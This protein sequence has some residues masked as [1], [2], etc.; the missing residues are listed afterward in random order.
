M[1]LNAIKSP[2]L[3][4]SPFF[5]LQEKTESKAKQSNTLQHTTSARGSSSQH[6]SNS[7]EPI[8]VGSSSDDEDARILHENPSTANE[9]PH[10]LY[11]VPSPAHEFPRVAQYQPNT[12]YGMTFFES[13]MLSCRPNPFALDPSTPGS[14]DRS[15]RLDIL[16]KI[17]LLP[18]SGRSITTQ[19]ST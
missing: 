9:D 14:N 4:D 8:K 13:P 7:G 3:F 16:S 1:W 11:V 15:S 6:V 18:I 12:H 10:A 2:L 19:I 17:K 5:A